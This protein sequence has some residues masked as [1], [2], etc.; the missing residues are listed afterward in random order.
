MA[1]LDPAGDPARAFAA[2]LYLPS[3]RAVSSRIAARLALSPESTHLLVGGVGSGKTTELLETKRRLNALPDTHALYLDVTKS[4]D[5]GRLAPGV[6]I[7]QVAIQLAQELKSSIPAAAAA[8][9]SFQRLAHGYR[10][11]FYEDDRDDG[12][13]QSYYVPGLLV[14]PESH[15]SASVH[16]VRD[17]IKDLLSEVPPSTFH[18][19]FLID[20]LDRITD[21]A[22]FEQLVIHDVKALASIGIGIVLVGPL[23]SLYGVDRTIVQHFDEL[24]YQPW[25][26]PTSDP[27]NKSFLKELLQRRL[28]EDAIDKSAIEM[29]TGH[30]GGVLRDLIALA[31]SACV[32]AYMGGSEAITLRHSL[33]AIDS[34]GRKHMQGLR[35]EELEVLQRVRTKASF[36]QT[37][38]NDLALLMT[39]RVLE[40]RANGLA[41]YVVHPT[42]ERF[43]QELAG[44]SS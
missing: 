5:A 22:A 2:E 20:G 3:T 11:E 32:E 14:S 35:A 1:Q 17:E 39:R 40:Y 27:S 8:G 37:S 25:I 38:E 26:D 16:R 41:R 10:E 7:I 15:I 31:Q 43:L 18:L 19:V 13:D 23:K 36:V 4:H 9:K 42:I 28:P 21:M 12:D 24:H 6:V 29:L 30:S 34:F 33:A 44:E